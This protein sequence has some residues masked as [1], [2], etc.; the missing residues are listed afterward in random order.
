MNT[1]ALIKKLLKKNQ[2]VYSLARKLNDKRPDY[3]YIFKYKLIILGG[4]AICLDLIPLGSTII[5]GGVGNDI[6]FE[7]ILVHRKNCSIIGYDPS[8]TA[9]FYIE[10]EKKNDR[11]LK[12]QY[13]F[14]NKAISDEA[15]MI[16]MF[17]GEDDFMMSTNSQHRN[18]I[19]NNMKRVEALSFSDIVAEYD[20]VAYVKL[21]IE[22]PEYGIIEK[23]T[24]CNIKQISIEF[25]HNSTSQFQIEDTIR[26][27]RKMIDLGYEVFDYGQYH[28]RK[29]RLP[30]YVSKW[31]DLNCEFLF[32]KSQ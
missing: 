10:A 7:R 18:V 15:G 14:H 4:K 12:N 28:G 24:S 6:E 21:D 19:S 30:K 5:S 13:I 16:D 3:Q 8:D 22:G 23:L 2:L 26:C 32:L 1:E 17:Y 27:V 29:R 9:K 25:H 20:N 31:S 11:K